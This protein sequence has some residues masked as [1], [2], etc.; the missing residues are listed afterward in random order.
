MTNEIK[1]ILDRIKYHIEEDDYFEIE[2]HFLKPLLDYIT[3]LQEEVEYLREQDYAWHQLLRMQNNREHRS[4][5][6]KDFQKEYGTN[7][8]PDYDEIYKRY[9]KLQKEN[10]KLEDILKLRG[11]CIAINHEKIDKAIKEIQHI[12]DYGFDYDGFNNVKDLKGLI[13]MLVDYAR[14]SKDILEGNDK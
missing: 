13:D 12:I 11:D 4:K 14:K 3:N 10:K 7:V 5:F 8:F 9:D 2:G 1:E 6:L